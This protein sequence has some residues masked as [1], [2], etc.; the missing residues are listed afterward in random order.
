[1]KMICLGICFGIFGQWINWINSVA[2]SGNLVTHPDNGIIHI[3]E[4][5][6]TNE[7]KGGIYEDP[8]SVFNSEY[9]FER[10]GKE[11]PK[12]LA[13]IDWYWLLRVPHRVLIKIHLFRYSDD[14][15]EAIRTIYLVLNWPKLRTGVTRWMP[16]NYRSFN[17]TRP[18]P[19]LSY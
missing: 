18:G 6:F 2:W 15:I 4:F 10:E 17:H 14:N 8:H 9:F 5:V 7:K 11:S 19:H 16:I 1:M 12:S 13:N 3:E